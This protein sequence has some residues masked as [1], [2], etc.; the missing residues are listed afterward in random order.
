MEG[1][2]SSFTERN[3][4]PKILASHGKRNFHYTGPLG[5]K[6]CSLQVF[7]F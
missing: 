2:S 6:E 5:K 4:S 1:R 7:L 3:L